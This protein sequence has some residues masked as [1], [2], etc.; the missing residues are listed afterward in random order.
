MRTCVAASEQRSGCAVA[1]PLLPAQPRC[2]C[3]PP[4]PPS[5]PSVMMA[6][7]SAALRRL[8]AAARPDMAR[9]ALVVR[10]MVGAAQDDAARLAVFR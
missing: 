9:A 7:L 6:A 4:L 2:L 3:H 8:M 10:S 5:H 1:A